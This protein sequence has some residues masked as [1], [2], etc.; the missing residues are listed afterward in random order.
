MVKVSCP[1]RRCTTYLK[2]RN[3]PKHR[4]VCLFERV[5]C[6]YSTIGCTTVVER[7]NLKEHERDSQYHLQLAVETVHQQQ[8]KIGNMQAHSRE[9]PV[10]YKFNNFNQHKTANDDIYSPAFYTSPKGYKMCI[11]VYANGCGDYKGTHVSVYVYLMKGE[12]DD[13]LPWPF[14]GKVTVELLNQLEDKNHHSVSTIFTSDKDVSQRV[15]DEERSSRGRGW[16]KYI[17]HSNLDRN[18]AINCQY[19]KDDRLHFKISVDAESSSTP[20]LI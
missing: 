14:T 19:L 5:P 7:K 11:K 10:V 6:K 13:Y 3:L 4:K 1:H 18:I 12:N 17:S 16:S 8:I 15:V 9:M 2:R 20:W